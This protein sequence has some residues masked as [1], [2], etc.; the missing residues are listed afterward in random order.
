[1]PARLTDLSEATSISSDDLLYA[2]VGGVSKKIKAAVLGKLIGIDQPI[3]N[4]SFSIWQRGTSSTAT[5]YVAADRWRNDFVGGTVTQSRQSHTIGTLFGQNS[6]PFF[7]RQS[8]TGQTLVSDYALTQQRIEGVRTFEGQT[9]TVLGWARRNSGTGNMAV[10]VVQNFGTGGSPSAEVTGTGQVVTLSAS[11]TAFA[12]TV[13]VPSISGKTLGTNN[14][15]YL[16]LNLWTSAGSNFNT[17]AGSIGVK[18]CDVDLWGLHVVRGTQDAALTQLYIAPSAVSELNRCRRYYTR[19]TGGVGS[20]FGNGHNAATTVAV[21]GVVFPI[22][23]RAAPT[24]LEQSGTAGHYG[25]G[26]IATST[27]CSAVPAFQ[28]ANTFGAVVTLT[29]ASG[30]TTGQGSLGRYESTSGFLA[31]AAEL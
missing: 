2:V 1:M 10:E 13:A 16:A 17:R 29:V 25:V 21:A 28:S 12:V 30:L 23:M 19:L 3:I 6:P 18:T 24:A 31:W 8:V 15:D 20:S 11:W 14:D 7:L 5:G 22:E 26:Y 27:V 4:G 9:I